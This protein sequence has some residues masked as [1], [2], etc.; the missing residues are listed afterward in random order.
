MTNAALRR[1]DVKIAKNY[2]S[3]DELEALNGVV[4][5]YL[6]FAELQAKNRRVMYMRDW[7]AKLDSF[8]TLADKDVLTGAAKIS[9][10]LA[11]ERASTQYE[12]FRKQQAQFPSRAERDFE[13]M[14]AETKQLEA[15]VEKAKTKSRTRKEEKR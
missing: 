13:A 14:I 10:E 5:A 7:I 12:L 9:H 1:G 8:L 4:T 3:L 6:E 11:V 15:T 2:L